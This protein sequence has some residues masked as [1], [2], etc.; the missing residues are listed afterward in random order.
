[1]HI[2]VLV[3]LL[4]IGAPDLVHAAGW[5]SIAGA[6]EIATHRAESPEFRERA[7]KLAYGTTY[8]F[9]YDL[10]TD[11]DYAYVQSF[12]D[13]ICNMK[14]P[15]GTYDFGAMRRVVDSEIKPYQWRFAFKIVL[16]HVKREARAIYLATKDQHGYELARLYIE[17]T[18]KGAKAGLAAARHEHWE[19]HNH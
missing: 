12:L 6:E 14:R 4:W 2:I 9:F 7:A 3:M 16:S 15:D 8:D 5:T 10:E 17:A 13:R 18:F 19:R 1:M 11:A